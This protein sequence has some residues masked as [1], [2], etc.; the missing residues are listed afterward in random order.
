MEFWGRRG[1]GGCV[2]T[3]FAG[4]CGR[5]EVAGG[6]PGVAA[7]GSWWARGGV[8]SRS[9]RRGQARED[10]EGAVDGTS[11][12]PAGGQAQRSWRVPWTRRAGVLIRP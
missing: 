3:G 5:V 10:S 11:P 7:V 1:R 9:G 6:V 8:V 2:G 4:L 12:G